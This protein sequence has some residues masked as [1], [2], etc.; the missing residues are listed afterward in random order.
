MS[1]PSPPTGVNS[2]WT[3]LMTAAAAT[4]TWY[5]VVASATGLTNSGFMAAL[6]IGSGAMFLVGV[7]LMLP[8][9]TWRLGVGL[10]VGAPAA[11]AVETVVLVLLILSVTS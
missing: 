1:A 9:R 11:F 8:K 3:G 10:A 4:A 5:F 2:V 6:A 7:L